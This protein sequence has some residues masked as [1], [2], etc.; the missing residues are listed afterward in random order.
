MTE[1]TSTEVSTEQSMTGESTTAIETA[2]APADPKVDGTVDNLGRDNE[3]KKPNTLY[4][5]G[6][7]ADT[8]DLD[9]GTV[10]TD[11]VLAKMNLA[12]EQ[13]E[14]FEKQ[15]KDLRKIVSKGKAPEKADV[16]L[17]TYDAPE[18]LE[19]YYG[20]EGNED[21]KEVMTTLAETA[22]DLGL[23]TD[24]FKSVADVLNNA[25]VKAKVLDTRSDDAIAQEKADWIR[26]ENGKLSND[27]LEARAIVDANVKFVKETTLL[28]EGQKKFLVDSMDKG[29]IGISTVNVFRE[30]FGGRGAD[31]PTVGVTDTGLASE[32]SLAAEFYAKDTSNLRRQEIIQQRIEGG[33]KGG[34]PLPS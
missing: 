3:G 6:F 29:A 4:P 14:K 27:P 12:K 23:N 19:R 13:A 26:S 30:L 33:R 1:E 17:E 9:N 31:I 15:A 22:K 16:Y 25:M 34:L 32:Q 21:V 28:D 24:Q 10:K 20:E 7:D 2:N 11:A 5:E 18:G 8:Y